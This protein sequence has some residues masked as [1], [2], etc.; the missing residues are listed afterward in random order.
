[1][2]IGVPMVLGSEVVPIVLTGCGD[3]EIFGMGITAG[4]QSALV[5]GSRCVGIRGNE[6]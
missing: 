6:G 2:V 5:L 4:S 3:F 1:M